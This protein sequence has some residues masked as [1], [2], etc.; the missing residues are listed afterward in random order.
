[1]RYEEPVVDWQEQ[2]V[3][4]LE[5][6]LMQRAKDARMRFHWKQNSFVARLN[7]DKIQ[8]RQ[9][10]AEAAAASAGTAA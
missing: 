7:R 6:N 8:Q 4:Q 5:A 9:R 2:A 10:Q 3:A 1:M